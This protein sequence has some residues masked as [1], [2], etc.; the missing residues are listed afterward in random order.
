MLLESVKR[1]LLA[2]VSVCALAMVPDSVPLTQNPIVPLRQSGWAVNTHTGL[3][4]LGFPLGAVSGDIPVPV[5]FGVQGTYS[6]DSYTYT[7]NT[8]TGPQQMPGYLIRPAFGALHFGFMRNP[9]TRLDGTVEPLITLLEDGQEYDGIIGFG[10]A[11]PSTTLN[12]YK[13]YGFA[14]PSSPLVDDGSQHLFFDLTATNQ[15]G[16][17]AQALIAANQ[18]VGLGTPT[19]PNYTVAY[20]VVMDRN[21]AR[22]F[23]PAPVLGGWVPVL[24]MDRFG[25]TV[26]FQWTRTTSNLPSGALAV[27]SVVAT[28]NRGR[29]VQVSWAD[30]TNTLQ[31]TVEDLVRVDFTGMSAPSFL[32]RGYPS[33]VMGAPQSYA[34]PP[35]LGPGTVL[36]PP[37]ATGGPVGRPTVVMMGDPSTVPQPVWS[38]LVP[39]PATVA[40]TGPSFATQ[41]WTLTWDNYAIP[42]SITAPSG[43]TSTFTTAFYGTGGASGP[44]AVGKLG[45]GQVDESDGSTTH[46]VS[47]TRTPISWVA[48]TTVVMQNWWPSASSSGQ[49]DQEWIYTYDASGVD[50]ITDVPTS[51]VLATASGSPLVT[52]SATLTSS[53]VAGQSVQATQNTTTYAASLGIPNQQLVYTYTDSSAL[54]VQQ[55]ANQIWNGSTYLT[56]AKSVDSYASRWDMLDSMELSSAVVT[57]Y[58]ASG[59]NALAPTMTQANVYDTPGMGQV[60]LLQLQKSYQQVGSWQHGATIGYDTEGRPNSQAVYDSTNGGTST[61]T[62]P[63]SATLAYDSGSGALLSATTSYQD[64]NS[65]TGT[66]VQSQG[67]LDANGRATTATDIKGVVSQVGY[68]L[69]GRI[70]SQS[71][72]GQAAVSATWSGDGKVQT[73]T[74]SAKI[75]IS[76]YDGFGR[77]VKQQTPDGQTITIAYDQDGRRAAKSV[78]AAVVTNPVTGQAYPAQVTSWSYDTLGRLISQTSPDGVTTTTSY[79]ASGVN[80][81]QDS[82]NTLSKLKVETIRDPFGQILS[83]QIFDWQNGAYVSVKQASYTYDG[84]GHLI[85][86]QETDP[87]GTVQTRSFTYDANGRLTAKTEPETNGQSFGGFN[88]LGQPTTITEGV[89]GSN[90]LRT[91]TLVY[92]GLGRLRA[93]TNG[94]DKTSSTFTGPLLTAASTTSNGWTVSQAFTYLPPAQGA[95]LASEYTIQPDAGAEINYT[96]TSDGHLASLVYPNGRVVSYAYADTSHPDRITSI[97]QT[98]PGGGSGGT[99]ATVG[100]D[101]GWGFRTDLLF[102]SG[103]ESKWTLQPDGI[104]LQ[105]WKVLINGTA[106]DVDRPYAYDGAKD[107]L[108]QAGEWSLTHDTRGRLTNV[109]AP[110]LNSYGATYGYDAFDNN[111]TANTTGSTPPQAINFT[112]GALADNRTPALSGTLTPSPTGWTYDAAGEATNYGAAVGSLTSPTGLQWDGLGRMVQ[113]NAPSLTENEGYAPSGLRVRRDD[114]VATNSRRYAYTAGGLLLAEYGAIASASDVHS[115]T[116]AVAIAHDDNNN[117]SLS[118]FLGTFASGDALT[119]TVWAKGPAGSKL[120]IYLGNVSSNGYTAYDQASSV[121]ATATGSW[122]QLTIHHTMTHADWMWAYIYGDSSTHTTDASIATDFDD[123]VVSSTVQGTVLNEGFESGLSLVSTSMNSSGWYSAGQPNSVI[124]VGGFNASAWD[125]DVIYLGGQAIAEIDANGTHELHS[126]HLGTPRVTTTVSG[127][128]TVI[129]GHQAYGPYGEQFPAM[130]TGYQPLTGYTGHAQTEPT[131]LIYMRGRFYTPTWHRFMNSDQ[132]AD[133]SIWNQ[134]AYVGGSPMMGLDPSGMIAGRTVMFESNV[135]DAD[136]YFEIFILESGYSNE[137]DDANAPHK[138]GGAPRTVPPI[139][140]SNPCE[141]KVA[142]KYKQLFADMGLKYANKTDN[143]KL[144]WH[145]FA[146]TSRL[147]GQ[148][149]AGSGFISTGTGIAAS[150]TTGVAAATL[151]GTSA[152]LGGF[153]AGITI[154]P[155]ITDYYQREQ[156]D[157]LDQEIEISDL[158]D[159]EIQELKDCHGK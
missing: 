158:V 119:Y 132:G 115:G 47:W 76:T 17:A 133:G 106:V 75:A 74:Q 16:S 113:V 1:V 155:V 10:A 36:V 56:V 143:L 97:S 65:G 137:E 92:D 108:S 156:D 26:T 90:S 35:G 8:P 70:Y 18:P 64:V 73:I 20:K 32:V 2:G 84:I 159:K 100:Y 88:A 104:H 94:S 86:V 71:T 60:P 25:H 93:Q 95:F 85:Q 146:N 72:S 28:N 101:P 54:Q 80:T 144:D 139:D 122:Q 151:G 116:H 135:V 21:I 15:M 118:H 134:M 11:H 105:D 24:W 126:D 39:T 89:V 5:A 40:T 69:L 41:Q 57:R 150:G 120:L 3:L 154:A 141:A 77:L 114:S 61:N 125:R 153:G 103:A 136:L 48:P 112:F 96:Y 38:A 23:A 99:V 140:Y 44:V 27:T 43:V 110:T 79:S 68:D 59:A 107:N 7:Q 138:R 131:G 62:A 145:Q 49:P 58:D 55:A 81:V 29:G 42:T 66:M 50:S 4:T 52:T 147:W 157:E 152:F 130:D 30:W 121:S 128:S 33:Y 22:I 9:F 129:D 45:I 142:D 83:T 19:S 51:V 12:L 31:T 14:A 109:S 91:R 124:L 98:A 53:G 123:V 34:Y 87:S 148:I 117:S 13:A 111:I 63:S 67:G 78:S 46:R 82:I 127:G 149:G 102:A 37:S 6:T